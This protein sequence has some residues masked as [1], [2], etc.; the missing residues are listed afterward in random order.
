[1]FINGEHGNLKVVRESLHEILTKRRSQTFYR[2]LDLNS[3][4]N[5][6]GEG[7]SSISK[8]N[9]VNQLGKHD[10]PCGQIFLCIGST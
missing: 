1:M 6:A 5:A 3:V 2:P 7:I 8:W 10:I 4:T 9:I